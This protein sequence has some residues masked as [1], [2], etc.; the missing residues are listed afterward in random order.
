MQ[1]FIKGI[2]SKKKTIFLEKILPIRNNKSH[3]RNFIDESND[4]REG[5][6][7]C[8]ST[9]TEFFVRMFN[10]LIVYT[11]SKISYTY[12]VSAATS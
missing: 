2:F 12:I 5:K 7:E 11:I 1:N 3:I 10:K 8:S 4:R 6:K 9:E